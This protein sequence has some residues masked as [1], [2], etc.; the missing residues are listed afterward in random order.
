MSVKNMIIFCLRMKEITKKKLKK[1]KRKK[2]KIYYKIQY[3]D[4]EFKRKRY[5]SIYRIYFFLL[6]D[7]YL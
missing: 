7:M 1:T 2:Y 4:K 5:N 6:K 3:L